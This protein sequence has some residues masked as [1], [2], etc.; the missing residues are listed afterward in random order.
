MGYMSELDI[1]LHNGES[2]EAITLWIIKIN[3]DRN[4]PISMLRAKTTAT[5]FY[6]DFHRME[7]E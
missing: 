4:T 6:E 5:H 7:E 1:M 3:S 2:I